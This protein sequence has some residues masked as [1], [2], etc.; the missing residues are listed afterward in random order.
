MRWL[1]VLVLACALQSSVLA[2]PQVEIK[3]QTQLSLGSVRLRGDGTVEVKGQLIDKLTS[4]GLGNQ[5]VTVKV[6]SQ[7]RQTYTDEDGRFRATLAGEAG[8]QP[9]ALEFKGTT[10]LDRA[11]P[12]SIM[13]DPSRA[14]VSLTIRAEVSAAG[15]SLVVTSTI[16]D[17]PV[18]LPVG[19][20]IGSP[21]DS[22]MR[23]L[24][25]IETGAPFLL[26]RAAAGGAGSRR[27]R[28]TFVG[29]ETRQPAS[30]DATIELSTTTTTTMKVAAAQLAYEDSI[31]ATGR[32]VDQD[33]KPIARAAVSLSA[34]D[35]RLSQGATGADGTYRFEVEAEIL[36]KGQF[37]IYVASDPGT[38]YIRPSK[39]APSIIQIA[40][41]QPVPVSY[42]IAA[43]LATALAAGGFFLA[44]SK[45]WLRFRK[46][47]P[48]ADVPE[49]EREAEG[50]E[51]G[52]VVAKP[53]LVSTLRRPQDDGFSGVVRDTVRARPVADAIIRL[54]LGVERRELRTGADGSFVIEG[55]PLGEWRA[56]VTA[57]GHVTE[58]FA[59]TIPHR[60]E[61]RGVRVDLVPVRERVFQLYRRAA[62]PL[63]PEPRLWGIW[64]PRQIVDHV[65]SR[66]PRPALAELTDFVEEVYFSARV[67]PETV[68]PGASERVDRAI[69]ERTRVAS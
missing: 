4:E 57:P 41:P 66:H 52:L 24:Q 26:T 45:P 68:L 47:A 39:S 13:T 1:A 25:V 51:G 40:A 38:S 17:Q 65:R 5:F 63:L 61:L 60:G 62:E 69:H 8:Q 15:A 37:G 18:P 3:A 29:D 12:V 54:V 34:G 48:P 42:T 46:A 16:D 49:N 11:E 2:A 50:V 33:G 59:V 35:R 9:V 31:V 30:A 56:E 22:E 55:L 53:G 23:N 44:R 27:V 28:A 36:G 58:Q 67:A 10:L 21:G 32:V 20:S 14:Q 7:V 19:L 64:S 43:F 6:G